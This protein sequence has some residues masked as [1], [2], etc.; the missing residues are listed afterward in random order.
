MANQI[1]LNGL[2]PLTGE[3]LV[4]P[5]DIS[6]AADLADTTAAPH[7]AVA[8]MHDN[9]SKP[10]LGLPFGIDPKKIEQ[11]GWGLV[12][13]AQEDPGVIAA[14]DPL[15]Q[16][17]GQQIAN[18]AKVKKLT[19][20]GEAFEDWLANYGVAPGDVKPNKVPFYLL[21]VGDPTKIPF[22]FTQ[23]LAV[24]YAV[25]RLHLNGPADYQRYVKAVVDYET[26]PG[27]SNTK[28]AVFFGTEHINDAATNLSCEQ[29]MKPLVSGADGD[30][31][32]ADAAGFKTS[33]LLSQA[34]TKK[35]LLAYLTRPAGQ[36]PP[37]VV[38][39]ATHGLGWP[40]ADARQTNLQGALLCGDWKGLGFSPLPM[41][42][43]QFLAAAD[44]QDANVQN[45]ICFFFACFGLATPAFDKFSFHPPNPPAQIAAQPFFS[46]LPKALL[47]A[48]NG[49]ALAVIGH[50]ERAWA[51]SI[52]PPGAGPQIGAFQFALSSILAGDPLG[53]AL[54][55]FRDRF[56]NF[57][58]LLATML[59]NKLN[60]VAV[61]PD[62]LATTW[63]EQNDAES[64]M[65]F[66]DPAI[67][68]RLDKLV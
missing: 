23:L 12:F 68:L 41:T 6:V 53:L 56:G 52:S 5:L 59:A 11:S 19:F 38:F 36:N 61:D 15:F 60:N 64:Y 39:S 37:A 33:S 49:P 46:P 42:P 54:M 50:M 57:S 47:S 4:P 48:T 18:P 25:G 30:P 65:L 17:R 62:K 29:L 1:I 9:L 45:L 10:S 16:H 35:G 24:N 55:P 26:T 31:G 40:L 7:P 43:D 63:T 44:V 22:E 58:A 13:H 51:S 21:V 67:R 20:N 3:Y 66:G 14:F 8:A 32:I 34:A 27:A 28:E 2:N